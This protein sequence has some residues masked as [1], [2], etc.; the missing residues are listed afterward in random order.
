MVA[1]AVGYRR[2]PRRRCARAGFDRIAPLRIAVAAILLEAR[3][4]YA[5][6][7]GAARRAENYPWIIGS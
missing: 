4:D 6:A 3:G 1:C 2:S 7:R 5:C